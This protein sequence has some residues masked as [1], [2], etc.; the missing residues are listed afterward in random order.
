MKGLVADI[1]RISKSLSLSTFWFCALN[2][3]GGS[4]WMTFASYFCY[5]R[6]YLVKS[7][8]VHLAVVDFV[9]WEI[10]RMIVNFLQKLVSNAPANVSLVHGNFLNLWYVFNKS[11]FFFVDH[12]SCLSEAQ[13]PSP[14][15]YPFGSFCSEACYKV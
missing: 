1:L 13:H 6:M 3:V 2:R 4:F 5:F 7:G 8:F 10:P 15:E 14:T 11:L 9:A 12:V